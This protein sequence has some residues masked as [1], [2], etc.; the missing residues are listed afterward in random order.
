[1][2]K[3]DLLGAGSYLP[4]E[5]MAIH[6]A[7]CGLGTYCVRQPMIWFCFSLY[8]LVEAGRYW[9]AMTYRRD[10]KLDSALASVGGFRFPGLSSRNDSCLSFGMLIDIA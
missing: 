6:T 8:A 9:A 7:F 4:S 3:R 10:M 1:M 5:V 2:S